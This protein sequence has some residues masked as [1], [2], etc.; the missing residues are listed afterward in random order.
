MSSNTFGTLLNGGFSYHS[1][2]TELVEIDKTG[3]V[4]KSTPASSFTFDNNTFT[5]VNNGMWKKQTRL[6]D[7]QA[8]ALSL[9]SPTF[10]LQLLG[11][12][13]TT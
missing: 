11:V 6:S 1:S 4:T 9:S 10:G 12:K 7:A 8:T 5:N 2:S 13:S 3:A